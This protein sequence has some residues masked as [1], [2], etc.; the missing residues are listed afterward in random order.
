MGIK[1]VLFDL[2][3]TLLP[4]DQEV[5]IKAYFGGLAKKL[6]TVG[7]EPPKLIDSI[8]QGSA[9]MVKNNGEK[10]NEEVFW[11]RFSEVYGKDVRVDEP[12][13]EAY[14]RDDFDG[15]KSVCGYNPEAAKTVKY[16]KSLGLSVALATNP[17][18]PYIATEKRTAWAGLSVSDFE[19]V[20][21][22]ENSKYCKPNPKYYECILDIMGLKASET[23]MVGNDVCEDMIAESLGMHVFLLTDNLIN[24]ESKDVSRYPNGSF[25][26]LIEYVKTLI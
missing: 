7:Y 5:F 22:Y 13:F 6:A 8:W 25:D 16:I 12:Y 24:K 15:V 2:D 26:K 18:F 11:K 4:M 1:A 17:L 9:A 10:T 20:T 21:T 23:L 19:L 14:Y 3:G